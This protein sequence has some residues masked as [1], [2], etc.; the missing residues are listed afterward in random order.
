[1][2]YP[3][4]IIVVYGV[5]VALGGILG[6]VKAKSIPSLVFGVASGIALLVCGWLASSHD[7]NGIRGAI[8]IGLLLGIFF[9]LRYASTCKLMPAGLMTVLSLL[10]VILLLADTLG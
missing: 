6:Y 4:L 2:G 1:M 5:L 9:G 10:A 8:V 7:V 3:V